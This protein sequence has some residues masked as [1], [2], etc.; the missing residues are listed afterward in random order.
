VVGV[1]DRGWSV[2]CGPPLKGSTGCGD[3]YVAGA[4]GKTVDMAR[5][6]GTSGGRERGEAW[7]GAYETAGYGCDE[8][9]TAWLVLTDKLGA[10]KRAWSGAEATCGRA[11]DGGSAAGGCAWVGAWVGGWGRADAG[12]G[13]ED[14]GRPC[15]GGRMWLALLAGGS[16]GSSSGKLLFRWRKLDPGF[17]ASGDM[18]LLCEY[19]GQPWL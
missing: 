4:E 6:P 17:S 3:A 9:A 10:A 2:G 1:T 13:C 8:A 18:A 14:I 11:C 12:A 5:T 16:V 19:V 7:G 15:C